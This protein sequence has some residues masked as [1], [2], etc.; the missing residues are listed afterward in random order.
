MTLSHFFVHRIRQLAIPELS[1][2]LP[3]R[4]YFQSECLGMLSLSWQTLL[5]VEL[6]PFEIQHIRDRRSPNPVVEHKLVAEVH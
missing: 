3:F 1:S 4:E 5:V 6:A 2:I